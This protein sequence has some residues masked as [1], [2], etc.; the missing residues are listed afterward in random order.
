M[1]VLEG[2]ANSGAL[3]CGREGWELGRGG[4]LALIL[5]GGG[6]MSSK[7]SSF[8]VRGL[9]SGAPKKCCAKTEPPSSIGVK[10]LLDFEDRCLG[11]GG[12]F[13]SGG[14]RLCCSGCGE[15]RVWG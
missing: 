12:L 13:C 11:C 6:L 10:M 14:R 5:R 9:G 1:F 7:S 15:A 8:F 4:T 2:G 3:D